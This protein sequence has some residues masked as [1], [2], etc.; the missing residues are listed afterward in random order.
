MLIYQC[1]YY[2]FVYPLYVK[3][4]IFNFNLYLNNRKKRTREDSG[5][6]SIVRFFIDRVLFILIVSGAVRLFHNLFHGVQ[7]ADLRQ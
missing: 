4:H 5:D 3:K 6:L 2:S 7:R 1:F